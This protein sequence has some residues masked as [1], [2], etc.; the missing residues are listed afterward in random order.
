MNLG[1][2]TNFGKVDLEHLAFPVNMKVDWI[3]VYQDPDQIN[4]GCDPSDF[5]T[6]AYI[7]QYVHNQH[8]HLSIELTIGLLFPSFR[9]YIEAY[10]N[11]NLTTWVND[12]QQTLP[13]NSFLGQC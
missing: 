2:S 5:P 6:E 10:T 4:Y 1:M 7:N 12:F 3:R 8:L 11:P 9:R 13:K